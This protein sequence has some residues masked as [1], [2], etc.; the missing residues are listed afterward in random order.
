[1]TVRVGE[2]NRPGSCYGDVTAYRFFFLSFFLFVKRLCIPRFAEEQ[3]RVIRRGV[4]VLPL[5]RAV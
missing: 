5:D 4:S 2:N 3:P 1:M